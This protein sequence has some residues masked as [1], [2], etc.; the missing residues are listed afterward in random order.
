LRA[1]P[2]NHRS[3]GL[4]PRV[5]RVSVS[6][7]LPLLSK[8]LANPHPRLLLLRVS[9]PFVFGGVVSSGNPFCTGSGR[10]LRFAR[11]RYFREHTASTAAAM[12]GARSDQV[13]H[14]VGHSVDKIEVYSSSTASTI[15]QVVSSVRPAIRMS[16]SLRIVHTLDRRYIKVDLPLSSG[17]YRSSMSFARLLCH[18]LGCRCRNWI[19]LLPTDAAST[20]KATFQHCPAK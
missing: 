4:L 13:E 6:P 11:V 2:G 17:F 15:D 8:S 16:L 12:E 20:G 9:Q 7:G 3:I 18:K 19:T 10:L 14:S 5:Q 1:Q